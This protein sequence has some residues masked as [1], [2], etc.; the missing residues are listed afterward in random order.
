MP[1]TTNVPETIQELYQGVESSTQDWC[2]N[3]GFNFSGSGFNYNNSIGQK[4]YLLKYFPA[5]LC[6]YY[7]QYLMAIGRCPAG[8]I[9]VLSV[10]CGAGID[11]LGLKLALQNEHYVEKY[12]LALYIGVDPVDWDD[13]PSDIKFV[14]NCIS[15]LTESEISYADI[16]IFPKSI[17]DIP[18]EIIIDFA[19]KL[20]SSPKKQFVFISSY[21]TADAANP[22]RIHG[23]NKFK[24]IHDILTAKGWTTADVPS[25]YYYP[26]NNEDYYSNEFPEIFIYPKNVLN[27]LFNLKSVCR[28]KNDKRECESCDPKSIPM[29]KKK[30]SAWKLLAYTQEHP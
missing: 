8:D 25:R 26:K 17:M 9:N 4:F 28:P 6:D 21:I 27:T 5:Y 30:Y 13:R 23:G 14:N 24:I 11:F 2:E 16:I 29:M 1:L 15:S 22:D 10:G 12:K 7:K 19:N 20:A 18:D 3:L